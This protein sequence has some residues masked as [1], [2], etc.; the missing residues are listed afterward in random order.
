MLIKQFT[1]QY[2]QQVIDLTLNIQNNE[3][4]ISL[5]LDEQPD[6]K[7]IQLNYLNNGNF[8]IAVNGQ[9][10]VIG[11]IAL[12][13]KGNGYGV[14][15]KFFVRQDYRSRKVGWQL[16][17]SFLNYAMEHQFKVIILDTSAVAK[18]SHRF[19]ERNGFKL[20]SKKDLPI[21]YQYPDRESYLYR[22]DLK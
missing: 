4:K 20:I 2:H 11:T 7:D 22:L 1:D 9:N 17:Q 15:K 18:A 14:L 13:N 19:Y 21:S 3:A 8:W 12:M 6:L 10:E 5:T 16:Y